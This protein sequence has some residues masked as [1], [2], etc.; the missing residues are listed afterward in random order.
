M[1]IKTA[2]IFRVLVA[3]TAILL[4]FAGQSNAR[5]YQNPQ[6]NHADTS[7]IDTLRFP[8]S[9]RY[10]DPY[11]N[12]NR[13]TFDLKDTAFIKRN[14]EYDPLTGQYYV[15]EKIGDKN[16]RTPVTFTKDEFLRLQGK[17][18]E[19]AYFRKRA[20]MLSE[21]NRRLFKP[22]FTTSKSWFNRIVGVGKIDIKP[23][24]YVDL[25]A[26]YQGQNIKNPTL[27]ERA[28]RNG[29]LDFNMNAQ[30]QVDANIGDKLK[31]PINYNT[32]AN[33]EFENQLNLNYQG[34]DDE[35][36]KQ[37]QLGNINFTSKG[38]LIP[39]A[40]SLFGIKTQLQFGKLFVTG[41]L[42]PSMVT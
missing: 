31:L 4:V 34:K 42:A 26:G 3:I 7:G 39:G 12:P 25:L 38:T 8:L 32:L 5:F 30:L 11:T 14:V 27:P 16:Y 2:H 6:T 35:I 13:N 40:Q 18:D 24:G 20:D 19:N 37:F 9:D 21:M 36:I 29:G 28:R 10:G 22:K 15:I 33:F 23:S 17:K 1:D 41:V